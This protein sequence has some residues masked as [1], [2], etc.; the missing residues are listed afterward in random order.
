MAQSLAQIYL[1]IVFSTKLRRPFLQDAALRAVVHQYLGGICRNLE[2]PAL[3]VGGVADHV[4]LLCRMCRTLAVAD[5][6]RTLKKDSSVWIKTKEQ[7]LHDFHW[8]DGYAVFSLS[9]SHVEAL[10]RYIA[11]QEQHHKK[12][13]FQDE[14]RRVFQKYGVEYDERF[15]WD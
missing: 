1:H 13:S 10:R 11:D 4:H 6:V 5:F 14:L 9:P 2:A 15:V 3:A 7:S 12:Q 8:Q